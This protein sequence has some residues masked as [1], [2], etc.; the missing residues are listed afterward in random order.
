MDIFGKNQPSEGTVSLEEL[1]NAFKTPT[2]RQDYFE[3]PSSQGGDTIPSSLSSPGGPDP[4]EIIPE[5]AGVTVSPE[6]AK[7]TGERIA[8][9]IDTGIDFALSNFVAHN[10][11]TYRADSNDLED[12]AECWGEI[13]QDHNWEM[14]P[15]WQLAILYVMVYGPLVKQAVTDRRL[16]ELE[17][18]QKEL[19]ARMDAID[20]N[21]NLK[22]TDNEQPITISGSPYRHQPAP[23]AQPSGADA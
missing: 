16:A 19:E 23:E 10:S 15:E 12:I 17:Q 6:K 8:K 2:Q 14:S 20:R 9:V 13:A 22:P 11:E 21:K 4:V 18:R 5:D 1:E 7:R 3:Q